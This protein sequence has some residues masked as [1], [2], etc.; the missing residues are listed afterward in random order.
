MQ[1]K[2]P[3]FTLAHR[4]ALTIFGKSEGCR[5]QNGVGKFLHIERRAGE[6][7][8][9]AGASI[10]ASLSSLRQDLTRWKFPSQT[11]S[12]PHQGTDVSS[13]S[14]LPDGTKTELDVL[15]GNSAPNVGT[16]KAADVGASDKN[17]PMDCDPYDAGAEVGNVKI[18]GVNAFLGPFFRILA[19]S[20]CKLKLSKSICKQEFGRK[21]WDEGCASCIDFGYFCTLCSF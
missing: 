20:T 6:P 3:R 17:S 14:V 10:L 19:G 4:G 5:I 8:A 9:V 16:D 7:S 18:S 2:I 1:M 11:A 21:K 12:K 13:H 15:E